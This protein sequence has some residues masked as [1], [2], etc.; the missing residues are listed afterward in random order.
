MLDLRIK[1]FLQ[2]NGCEKLYDNL[3]IFNMV[4][5]FLLPATSRRLPRGGYK[6]IYEYANRMAKDGVSV[7]IVYPC[8]LDYGKKNIRVKIR[9]VLLYVYYKLTAHRQRIF[10]FN[11]EDNI[12]QYWTW[13]LKEKHIPKSD[14]IIATGIQ[15]VEQ[16][17]RYR[18]FPLNKML[19]FIQGFEN[20]TRSDIQV[21]ET[22]KYPIKKIVVS[23]WL[24]DKVKRYSSNVVYIPNAFDFDRFKMVVRPEFRNPFTLLVS[25]NRMRLKGFVDA[26][27]AIKILQN[28]IKN[29]RV[30][31]YGIEKPDFQIPKCAEFYL[32][33]NKYIF[34]DLYN[35]SAVF[36]ATSHE[37]GWGLPVGE[38]MQCATAVVCTDIGG[39]K[40]MANESN[41]IIVP[42][43]D[44]VA[45]ADAV[46]R[47]M[48]NSAFRCKIA[49]KGYNDIQRFTW[50]RSYSMFKSEIKT[51]YVNE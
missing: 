2:K 27:E 12:K 38:A 11:L 48:F 13:N 14:I 45:M 44:Y 51:L 6:V 29:L 23:R 33:P 19:Y 5:T 10:W 17:I 35:R 47:L 40:E 49:Y 46:E 20:W 16:L 37:E 21:Y 8:A 41:A 7:N 39:Y 1:V 25:Y 30:Y 28:R 50:N 26:L 9:M 32:L 4:V 43:G 42:V 24:L 31:I 15:T 3:C 22:Y 36:L 18:F 34:N